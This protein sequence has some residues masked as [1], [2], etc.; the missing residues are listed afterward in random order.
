MRRSK[1]KLK[2]SKMKNLKRRLLMLKKKDKMRK[3][4]PSQ[5]LRNSRNFKRKRLPKNLKPRK[6][7][8]NS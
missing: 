2:L 3:L 1:D 5:E 8:R 4:F 7:N 6:W